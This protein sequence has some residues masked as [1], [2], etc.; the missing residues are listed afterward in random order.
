VDV[1]MRISVYS[2]HSNDSNNV[3]TLPDVDIDWY[4]YLSEVVQI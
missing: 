2:G 1:I 4:L 3:L